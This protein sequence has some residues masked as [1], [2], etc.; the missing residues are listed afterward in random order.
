MNNI[1]TN[2]NVVP[3]MGGLFSWLKRTVRK[4]VAAIAHVSTDPFFLFDILDDA[5]NGNGFDF[6]NPQPFGKVLNTGLTQILEQDVNLTPQ[7]EASLDFWVD[8]KFT[9]Y[10]KTFFSKIKGFNLNP[11]SIDTFINYY[12]EAQEFIA[13]LKWYQNYVMVNGEGN[14]TIEAVRARNQFLNIQIGLLEAEIDNY[15]S[16]IDIELITAQTQVSVSTLKYSVLGFNIPG[17][18]DL[19]TKMIIKPNNLIGTEVFTPLE[20]PNQKSTS[21]GAG[22]LLVILLGLGI[23]QISKSEKEYPKSKNT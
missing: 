19:T 20:T 4:V 18:V 17:N 9:P 23:W 13:L 15:I 21:K 10:F 6:G 22:V 8:V 3:A 11:P 2:S 16:N 1:Q 14:L 5:F 12:N 7:D